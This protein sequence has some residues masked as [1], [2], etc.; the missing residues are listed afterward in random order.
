MTEKSLIK[1]LGRIKIH[2][3]DGL[4]FMK[5]RR[6]TEQISASH[7]DSIQLKKELL[8]KLNNTEDLKEYDDL[9]KEYH[10]VCKLCNES[11][12][13]MKETLRKNV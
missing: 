4:F 7:G 13:I 5:K 9:I 1:Y 2:K 3:L 8:S 12:D 6:L 10:K 11:K